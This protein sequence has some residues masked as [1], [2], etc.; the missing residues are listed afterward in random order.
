MPLTAEERHLRRLEE[1]LRRLTGTAVVDYSMINEGDRVMVACSGGK[2]STA[3][4]L[5][6][7][8]IARRAPVNFT[9]HP[10]LLDQ[11]IPKFDITAFDAWLTEEGFELEVIEEDTYSIV[12]EVI[13]EKKSYCSLC[14]RLRR[15]V[16]YSYAAEKGYNKIALGHH[17]DDVNQTLLMNLFF[18]GTLAAMP[19]MLKSKDG[20]N[21]IIRPFCLAPESL[22]IDYANALNFPIVSCEFCGSLKNQQRQEIGDLLRE[23]ETKHPT[24]A[25]SMV[26]AAKN[27]KPSHLLDKRYYQFGVT[28][29]T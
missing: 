8:E 23:L 12:A 14:A 27:I 13:D 11:K 20:R 1:K 3:L 4:L 24:L 7:R 9:L 21:T 16:L 26:A 28:R 15:G 5:I 18:E 19:P 25:S 22:I 6:L 17:R 29:P 2:D 10:V